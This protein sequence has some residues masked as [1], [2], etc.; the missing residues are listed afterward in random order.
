MKLSIREVFNAEAQELAV[1]GELSEED[2]MEV[3]I[4]N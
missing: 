2:W 1:E 3:N 4:A